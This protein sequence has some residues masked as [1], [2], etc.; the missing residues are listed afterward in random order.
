MDRDTKMDDLIEK[1][2]RDQI[3]RGQKYWSKKLYMLV[4]IAQLFHKN[5]CT[6]DEVDEILEFLTSCYKQK[7]EDM[8]YNTL[9]DYF[10]GI[11]NNEVGNVVVD[12][13]KHYPPLF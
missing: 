6:Y 13:M 8:E 5:N 10:S 3:S 7:R 11:K 1:G 2:I 9:D 12:S 4:E